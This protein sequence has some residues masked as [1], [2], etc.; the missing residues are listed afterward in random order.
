MYIAFLFQLYFNSGSYNLD[1]FAEDPS[2]TGDP[3][4]VVTSHST[5]DHLCYDAHGF[6]GDVWNLLED[7]VNGL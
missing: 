5:G 4:F 1:I 2:V 7:K 6:N 3:H